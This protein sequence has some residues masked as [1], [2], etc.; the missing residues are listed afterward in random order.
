MGEENQ[1]TSDEAFI[2]RFVR[3]S[4][5]IVVM[6]PLT[7]VVGYGGWLLLSITATLGLYDPETE[8][9]ELLRKRLAEWPDRNREVMRTDGVAELPLKP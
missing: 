8:T 9:G 6:V 2:E 3:L 7:V 5:S 4:V 1:N